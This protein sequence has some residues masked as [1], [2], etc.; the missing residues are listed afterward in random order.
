MNAIQ[1]IRQRSFGWFLAL[2]LVVSLVACTEQSDPGALVIDPKTNGELTLEFDNVVGG[3][4][5]ALGKAT[6]KNS[7]GEAFTVDAF[8]Y[9]V[10]NV[11]LKKA[12]GTTY[13][14]PNSYYLVRE[15]LASSQLVKLTDIPQG[16]YT[17]VS[18][19]LGVD[20]TKSASPV[21]ERIG[22][23]D[24]GTYGQAVDMYWSWNSGYI[25]VRLE[26]TSTAVP[27]DRNGY[28]ELHTGGFG[29]MTGK[30]VNNLRVVSLTTPTPATVRTRIAPTIHLLVD[31][32][33]VM[34]GSTK[35]SLTSLYKDR[36]F[37]G[38]HSPEAAAK[39]GL[40]DN[41]QGMFMVDHVHNDPK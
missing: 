8:N 40:P 18:F 32:G 2:S 10:S 20:S 36:T 12:D 1:H 23:L 21:T 38:I 19:V 35:I 11:V 26:G 9:F 5:L 31:A 34:D 22:A 37:N 30:T 17:G 25:F 29:G 33:K 15:S 27:A 14:V 4:N 7:F 16:D 6:Y 13:N 39:L 41:Q 24:P 28:Y 3:T